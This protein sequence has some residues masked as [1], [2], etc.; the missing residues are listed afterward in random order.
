MLSDGSAGVVEA[1]DCEIGRNGGTA[2]KLLN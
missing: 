1:R 2:Q